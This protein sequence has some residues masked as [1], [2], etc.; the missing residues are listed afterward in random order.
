M[1]PMTSFLDA[2][3][4]SCLRAPVWSLSRVLKWKL[5]VAAVWLPRLPPSLPCF[6]PFFPVNVTTS[7]R[8]LF[9]FFPIFAC[10]AAEYAC[11]PAI[12]AKDGTPH[13]RPVCV[14][15][16]RWGLSVFQTPFLIFLADS[17]TGSILTSNLTNPISERT[18]C[19]KRKKKLIPLFGCCQPSLPS[20]LLLNASLNRPVS[21]QGRNCRHACYPPTYLRGAPSPA[22][23]SCVGPRPAF[24]SIKAFSIF[25]QYYVFVC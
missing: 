14:L 20:F 15:F 21:L 9:F 11:H 23:P 25:P 22:V 17:V 6:L 3:W 16:Q 2:G 12:Y 4:L 5:G 13:S 24:C 7:L 18:K 8:S 10:V 1:N 19:S